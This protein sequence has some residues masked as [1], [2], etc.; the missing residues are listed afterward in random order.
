[1]WGDAAFFEYMAIRSA[2]A[3]VSGRQERAFACRASAG[4]SMRCLALMKCI[5]IQYGPMCPPPGFIM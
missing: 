2:R 1:M 3:V 5:A 4:L